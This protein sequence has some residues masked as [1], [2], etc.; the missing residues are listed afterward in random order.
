[1]EGQ[2]GYRLPAGD[3]VQPFAGGGPVLRLG[4]R[5][6][7]VQPSLQDAER[8]LASHPAA[9]RLDQAARE[10]R[11]RMQEALDAYGKYGTAAE[12]YTGTEQ[13]FREELQQ[14]LLPEADFRPG[15]IHRHGAA[16]EEALQGSRAR[17][18]EEVRGIIKDGVRLEF[19]WPYGEEQRQRPGFSKKETAVRQLLT[20]AGVVTP[21]VQDALQRAQPPAVWL[22]NLASTGGANRAFTAGAVAEAHRQ[23]VL[24]DWRP[25]WGDPHNIN[26]LGCAVNRK[27]KQRMVAAC[28]MVNFFL[29]YRR[30]TYEQLQAR[31]GHG[32]AWLFPPR[33]SGADAAAGAAPRGAEL[34][35]V[36]AGHGG[37]HPGRGFPVPDRRQERVPPLQ[38]APRVLEAPLC[39]LGRQGVL[40]RVPAFWPGLSLPRVHSGHEGA[41]EAAA[42]ARGADHHTDRRQGGRGADATAGSV[43]VAGGGQAGLCSGG[44][45]HAAQVHLLS[46][47]AGPVP[48][49]ESRHSPPLLL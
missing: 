8:A 37:L 46:P 27:G 38:G 17:E 26:P 16:W 30:F 5:Q 34:L 49:A 41:A 20:G 6:G 31:T 39:Q 47:A 4:L 23:G 21:E 42:P 15:E 9:A 29:R 11:G 40:L 24:L 48:G 22:G 36:A 33:C 25:E 44:V 10:C 35:V 32:G 28:L 19:T 1:M 14:I 3:L 18:A 45:L 13:E 2:D 43:Q 7:S 12:A